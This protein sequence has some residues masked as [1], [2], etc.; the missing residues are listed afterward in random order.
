MLAAMSSKD[1]PAQETPAMKSSECLPGL[2]IWDSPATLQTLNT[3]L[4]EDLYVKIEDCQILWKIED[5]NQESHLWHS[6]AQGHGGG[7]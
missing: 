6:H 1:S 2:R 5:G 3:H 7:Y 4:A